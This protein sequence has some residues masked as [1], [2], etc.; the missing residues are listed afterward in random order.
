MAS[1]QDILDRFADQIKM[2]ARIPQAFADLLG[3]SL[4]VMTTPSRQVVD[5]MVH[6]VGQRV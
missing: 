2:T 6:F 3:D 4:Y 5:D 1:H